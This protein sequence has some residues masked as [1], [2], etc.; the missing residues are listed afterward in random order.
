MNL[1]VIYTFSPRWGLPSTG[2]FALKLLAWVNHAGIAHTQAY[3]DRPEKG[4]LG[5]SP[6]MELGGTRMGDSDAIIA[7]LA[8]RQGMD[9]PLPVNNAGE[10]RADA[11][12]IAFEERFHQILEW[13][14]F[15]HPEGAAEMRRIVASLAPPVLAG[16]ITSRMIRHFSRQLHARG[17]GRLE[18]Q[19]IADLGRRQL[20]GLAL[21]LEEGDGWLGG[22]AP[23]LADFAVWGQVAPMLHWP[24]RGPVAA[25]ARSLPALADW[26]GRIMA[27]CF[28]TSAAA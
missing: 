4:P 21:C 22:D 8:K 11:L 19:V 28:A 26:H 6:W 23:A 16:L 5:K 14:L 1:P 18:A 12:K 20:D 3:E 15:V 17:I 9:D 13:E 24:M 2:P 25:H 7:H 27:A 10:A